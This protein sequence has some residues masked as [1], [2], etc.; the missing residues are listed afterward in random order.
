M[1]LPAA[2]RLRSAAKGRLT[3]ASNELKAGIDNVN[4]LSMLEVLFEDVITAWKN[5][6]LKHD[7]CVTLSEEIEESDV[8]INEVEGA[9]RETRKLYYSYKQNVEKTDKLEKWLQMMGLREV[10]FMK[11]CENLCTQI[12]TFPSE[13]ISNKRDIIGREFEELKSLRWEMMTSTDDN[14]KCVEGLKRLE[15]AWKNIDGA[16]DR[17]A[18]QALIEKK[19]S[20]SNVRMEKIPLPKFDGNLRNYPTFRKDFTELVLPGVQASQAPFTLRQC[21]PQDIIENILGACDDNVEEMLTRLDTKYG[22]SGKI[23]EAIIAE[24][25]KVKK[26]GC[27]D[28]RG[29]IKFVNVIDRGFRDLRKLK[30]EN[31]MSNL[32]VISIIESKLPNDISMEW[33][34][35]IYQN[36]VKKDNKFESLLAYLMIEKDALEHSLAEV[37]QSNVDGKRYETSKSCWIHKNESHSIYICLFYFTEQK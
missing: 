37:R 18:F 19:E 5:V 15:D 33:Y 35:R 23:A 32:N 27:E 14:V 9:F 12:N 22:D 34:R 17:H 31:E 21:L 8:W 11:G 10:E 13:M 20:R 26:L 6:E 16:V 1:D 30:L 25:K 7:Q 2:K 4:D 3:R 24:I 36:K 29:L 28:K